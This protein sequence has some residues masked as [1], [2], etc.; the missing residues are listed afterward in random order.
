MEAEVALAVCG[1][2]AGSR[3]WVP[4]VPD[5]CLLAGITTDGASSVELQVVSPGPG[6][7][8]TSSEKE[9]V[10]QAAGK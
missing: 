8:R 9:Q 7:M 10:L 4:A 5:G 1:G 2:D 3:S 6:G